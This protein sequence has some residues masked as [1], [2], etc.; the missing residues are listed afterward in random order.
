MMTNLHGDLH[1]A[2]YSESESPAI[3]SYAITQV[4]DKLVEDMVLKLFFIQGS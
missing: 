4:K 1:L 2:V 3:L